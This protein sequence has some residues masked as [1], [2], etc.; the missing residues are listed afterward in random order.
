MKPG[1]SQPAAG[2]EAGVEGGGQAGP[3]QRAE[4]AEQPPHVLLTSRATIWHRVHGCRGVTRSKRPQ[5]LRLRLPHSNYQ[6]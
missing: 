2:G 3:E 6:T 5:Q 1:L 4:W